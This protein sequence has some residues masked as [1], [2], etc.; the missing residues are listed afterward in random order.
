ME[1]AIL[2]DSGA[3]FLNREPKLKLELYLMV[4]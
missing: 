4:D 2:A 1:E 3:L